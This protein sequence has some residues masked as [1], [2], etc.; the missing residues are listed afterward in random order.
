MSPDPVITDAEVDAFH[1]AF[2][3]E[4]AAH[5]PHHPHSACTRAALSAF[6]KARVPEPISAPHY[7]PVHGSSGGW[8]ACRDAV[9][10]GK[11]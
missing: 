4:L 3:N 5:G 7:D 8:N 6:L 10:R 11:P 2:T 9:L 1:C